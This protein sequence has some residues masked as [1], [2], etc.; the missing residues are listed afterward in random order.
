M[1]M[2]M[3]LHWE[4][5]GASALGSGCRVEL[6]R[7]LKVG[8]RVMFQVDERAYSK[9]WGQTGKTGVA[10]TQKLKGALI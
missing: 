1:L 6:W 10:A 5:K 3:A 9:P 2:D 4:A 8:A 7:W